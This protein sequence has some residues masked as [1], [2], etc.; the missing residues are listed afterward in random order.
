MGFRARKSIKLAPGVRMT[1]TPKSVGLSAGPRGAR[2]SANT[3]GRVTQSVGIPGSGVSHVSTLRSGSSSRRTTTPRARSAQT[4]TPQEAGQPAPKPGIFAPRW[5]KDLHRA[6]VAKPDVRK[7]VRVAERHVAA[8]NIASLY[9]SVLY[10]IPSGHYQRARALIEEPYSGGFD[11]GADPFLRKYLPKGTV[12]LSVTEQ[13]TV[14]LPLD[15]DAL[16]LLL[17]ELRQQDG[18]IAGATAVTEALTP[19]TITAVSLAELYIE[20]RKWDDV[21]DLTEALRNEDEP[22]T[23]LLIQRGIA[24]REQGYASASRESFREALRV[25]SRQANLKHLALVERGRTNLADGKKA[26]ARKD[27]ERVLAEDSRYPGLKELLD[28]ITQN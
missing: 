15:R 23:Y 18:D 28:T 21:V 6:L 3:R 8:R 17:A 25:R 20:Q 22:T 2:I 16:G 12:T 1:V 26:M 5:E 11:P 9:E 4:R 19:T 13:V 24:L 14:T 10:A 7:L 27:F